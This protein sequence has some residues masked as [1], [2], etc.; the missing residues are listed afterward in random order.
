[1]FRLRDGIEAHAYNWQNCTMFVQD[2]K[3]PGTNICAE[4][5]EDAANRFKQMCKVFASNDTYEQSI[6]DFM[7]QTEQS[8]QYTAQRLATTLGEASENKLQHLDNAIKPFISHENASSNS[9]SSNPATLQKLKSVI[10][11]TDVLHKIPTNMTCLVNRVV[12]RCFDEIE[13]VALLTRYLKIF[14]SNFKVMQWGS[15]TYGFGGTSTNFNILVNTGKYSFASI[16]S[17][18]IL[19]QIYYFN[20]QIRQKGNRCFA[21][22]R[23]IIED[24]RCSTGFPSITKH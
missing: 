23:E 22:I 20:R 14:D 1:M 11:V 16:K 13:I 24:I 5:P 3:S 9:F 19:E 12:K 17:I 4:I 15:S 18:I 8:N 21:I 2:I 10:I 7:V 6:D